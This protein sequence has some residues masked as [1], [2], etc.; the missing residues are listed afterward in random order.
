[1]PEILP[2]GFGLGSVLF[3]TINSKFSGAFL[4]EK[5]I[6][7]KEPGLIDTDTTAA[8]F[9]RVFAFLDRIPA[10]RPWNAGPRVRNPVA[11]RAQTI[12]AGRFEDTVAMDVDIINDIM[13]GV[14]YYSTAIA[15]LG[16]AAARQKDRLVAQWLTGL[17]ET[18]NIYDG[19]PFFSASH[20]INM[21]NTGLGTQ[22]NLFTSKSLTAPNFASVYASF[23]T[24]LGADGTPFV[25]TD[26]L[27]LMH[28]PNLREQAKAL[29]EDEYFTAANAWSMVGTSGPSPNTLKGVAR[30][31]ENPYLS[32]AV[33]GTAA[34]DTTWYL[35]DVGQVVQPLVY[36]LREAPIL[37]PKSTQP[38]D[39]EYF[40]DNMIV[41]G[42]KM[43]AAAGPGLWQFAARAT[44]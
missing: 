44:A 22:A 26:N 15:Q 18:A 37:V 5:V 8:G 11:L 20:P 28:P 40:D 2:S 9:T 35:F 21:D 7:D 39:Q 25:M 24:I 10:L 33:T 6:V 1:M 38:S 41:Y 32:A 3:Q 4:N 23:K 12:T 43:R 16:A 17:A 29:M 19:V 42:L 30:C 14:D 27:V 31:L 36:W 13:G 34:D